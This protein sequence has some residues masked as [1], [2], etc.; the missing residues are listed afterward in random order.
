[1]SGAAPSF[2]LLEVSMDDVAVEPLLA[3]LAAEYTA[4]YGAAISAEVMAELTADELAPP[5]GGF[6]VLQDRGVT[7]AG[8][9]LRGIGEGRCELKRMWT[10]PTHRR[11]G[12]AAQVVRALEDLASRRGY[13]VVR[14]ETGPRQ[15]E[16]IAA[17]ARLGYTRIPVYGGYEEAVA[18]ERRLPARG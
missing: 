2:Q 9:G 10:A 5:G 8:G 7:V 1:M 6:V 17:Y 4:R 15:P 12:L 14:L 16:A 18:F 3:G 13:H 11:R